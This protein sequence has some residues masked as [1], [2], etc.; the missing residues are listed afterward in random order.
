MEK[1][2]G[3]HHT[4]SI[5]KNPQE[6][7]D[8]YASFFGLR[9]VKNTLN[10]ENRNNYH[11]YYANHDATSAITTHF[12][13]QE[14][15]EGKIGD[16]QVTTVRYAINKG[17]MDFWKQRLS[18]FGI[19][20]FTYT[21]FN[22]EY[23][24]FND[25]H[26][27][28]LELVETDLG[29]QNLW[30]FNHVKSKD[31]LKDIYN[32]TIASKRPED[33]VKLFTEI[34]GYKIDQNDT[35]YLRLK[36]HDDIGGTIDIRKQRSADGVE[37]TGTVHHLALAIPN[38]SAQQWKDKLMKAGFMPTAVK[39]RN[40]F[41]SLYFRDKGGITIELATEGP[42][43]QI[44]ESLETLGT[45]FIIPPHFEEFKDEI[46]NHIAPL[47]LQELG[48]LKTYGYRNK[49]EFDMIQERQ[50]KIQEFKALKASGDKEAIEN[51]KKEQLKRRL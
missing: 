7:L 31:A 4:S 24:A 19:F 6:N 9:L 17:S 34:F 39:N 27:L 3:I 46:L 16:G 23:L 26:G 21:R 8:F 22:D 12:P 45:T 20:Y 13:M 48:K 5:V 36:L 1:I 51:F 49:Q 37:G 10:H 50:R 47:H 11:L 32:V 18:D 35:E 41:E 2:L 15:E 44:D 38:G 40:Y 43:L 30:E 28:T 29:S 42:G 33:T 25:P 14:A